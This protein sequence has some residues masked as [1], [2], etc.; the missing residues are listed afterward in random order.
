M[1]AFLCSVALHPQ[2][3]ATPTV[4]P[5]PA[6]ESSETDLDFWLGEWVADTHDRQEDGT[7]KISKETATNKI[8]RKFDNKVIHEDFDLPGFHGES[9]SVFDAESKIWRQTWVDNSGNY[10]AFE[11]GKKGDEFWYEMKAPRDTMRMRF[12]EIK[13]DSFVWI[14]E[15][16][17]QDGTYGQV[18]RL[19]YRRKS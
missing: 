17:K 15:G 7:I 8:T 4:A 2:D 11:G 10:M 16:R 12:T 14:W 3:P 13:K 9:W 19:D 18:W 6:F 1:L 5:K